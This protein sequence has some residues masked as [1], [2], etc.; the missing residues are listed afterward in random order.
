[1]VGIGGGGVVFIVFGSPK[2]AR[3]KPLK[4]ATIDNDFAGA[5]VDLVSFIP[6]ILAVL[7]K[8]EFPGGF[9]FPCSGSTIALKFTTWISKGVHFLR[10]QN[11]F[12]AVGIGFHFFKRRRAC[13]R[14]LS[15]PLHW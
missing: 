11:Q 9:Q 1:M 13:S 12:V 3:F 15:W 14:P 4:V 5:Q 7:F 8:Y 2:F 6:K 10:L